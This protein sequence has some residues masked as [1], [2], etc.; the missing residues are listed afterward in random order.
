LERRELLRFTVAAAG[1]A[2]A[3]RARAF[4]RDEVWNAKK[5]AEWSEKDLDKILNNS[6]WTR[7]TSVAMGAGGGGGRSGGGR[8]G[9]GGGGGMGGGGPIGGG[10]GADASN[11]AGM[12]GQAMGGGDMGAPNV[13]PSVQVFVRWESALPIREAHKP[14]A[15]MKPLPEYLIVVVG[16]P[17][18]GGMGGGGRFGQ[19]DQSNTEDPEARKK[20]LMAQLKE[21][22]SLEPKGKDPIAPDL[23]EVAPEKRI[24]LA[25]FSRAKNPIALEDKEVVFSIRMGPMEVRT[26]FALKDMVYRGQLEL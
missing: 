12:G 6:P 11:S 18:M 20:R 17:L 16:M 15:E 5:P 4:G 23:V 26:K 1:A 14:G 10:A 19:P 21:A 2:M 7:K 8:R 22:T 25:H 3:D 24:I 9:G 13:V